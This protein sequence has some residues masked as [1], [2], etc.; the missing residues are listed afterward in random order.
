MNDDW[1]EQALECLA[2][3]EM[4]VRNEVQYVKT[5][6]HPGVKMRDCVGQWESLAKTARALVSDYQT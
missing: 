2:D 6:K 1:A 5:G 4:M 3:V